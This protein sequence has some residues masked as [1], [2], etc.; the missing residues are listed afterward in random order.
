VHSGLLWSGLAA[1]GL[2][3]VIDGAAVDLCD[4]HV[5]G[6]GPFWSGEMTVELHIHLRFHSRRAL[7][8]GRSKA[9]LARHGVSHRFGRAVGG[10]GRFFSRRSRSAAPQ[11]NPQECML[12]SSLSELSS[13]RPFSSLHTGR[14]WGRSSCRR[15]TP[16]TPTSKL[17][18][19]KASAASPLDSMFA[20]NSWGRT[21][22][23]IA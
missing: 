3:V 7:H 5:R 23:V 16:L 20:G 10:D 21:K 19:A 1:T 2:D 13:R 22:G 17:R 12:R 14:V 9:G 11:P 6:I 8:V 4:A 18:Y 15:P